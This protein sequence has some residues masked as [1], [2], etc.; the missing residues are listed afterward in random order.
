MKLRAAGSA[1]FWRDYYRLPASVRLVA[2]KNYH[3]WSEDPFHP[4]L[5]FKKVSAENWSVRVGDAL[6]RAGQIR[7]R[8][9]L[10]GMDRLARGL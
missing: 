8:K 3:L 7:R 6:P 1:E 10:V 4:S 2:R 5:H 9:L